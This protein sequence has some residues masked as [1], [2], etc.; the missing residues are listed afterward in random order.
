MERDKLIRRLKTVRDPRER[1]R[2]IWTL[3]GK[4]KAVLEEK[5]APVQAGRPDS[6]PVQGQVPGLPKL[7]TDSRRLVSYLAPAILLF[8]GVVNLV[9]AIVH[10]MQTGQ[11]EAVFPQLILGVIFFL[12]GFF[13]LA[14][15]RKRPQDV[16][17]DK[18][19]T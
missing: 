4:D 16:N 8:F 3:A 6:T 15:A 18:K 9:Q 5:P 11:I 1:D 13:S 19:E 2:I 17:A 14:R 12:F 10:F 7:P